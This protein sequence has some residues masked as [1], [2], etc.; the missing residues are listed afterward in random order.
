MVFPP[1]RPDRFP[2]PDQTHSS[3]TPASQISAS[4]TSPGQP[5]AGEPS[6]G[7]TDSV[8]TQPGRPSAGE[9]SAGQAPPVRS[10]P[11]EAVPAAVSADPRPVLSVCLTCRDGR[12][13]ER[14]GARGGARLAAAILAAARR[15]PREA[16]FRGVRC[17]SQCKRPCVVALAAPGAF[18]YVFGDLDPED[19][20]H[21]AAVLDLLPRYRAAPEGLLARDARPEPLRGSILGRLPP[22]GSS[23]DLVVFLDPDRETAP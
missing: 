9:T 16:G 14:E 4:Q 6:P 18:T 5:S 2:L 21:V 13:A 20:A 11:A 15:R 3:Q 8:Q 10:A 19:P 22:E 17:M 23:S 7:Q 1:V 12:E